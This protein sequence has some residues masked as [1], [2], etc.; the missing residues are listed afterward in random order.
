MSY[1]RIVFAVFSLLFSSLAASAQDRCALS[2]V[3]AIDVSS[4]VN[5]NEYALQ[6][7]GLANALRDDDVREAIRFSGGIQLMAFEWSGRFQQI[8]V[9]P[10]IYLATDTAIFGAA[11]RIASHERSYADL[12]TALGFALG[13]ASVQLQNAPLACSRQAIDVSGDGVSNDGFE[14]SL[15]Y[16]NFVFDGVQVNGL[17]I[18]GATPDPVKY[19]R[20]EVIY[21]PGAFIE[22]AANFDDFERAMKRKLLREINGSSLSMLD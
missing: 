14:P 12:P 16:S 18:A 3:L 1:A 8:E 5:A 17:V 22:V 13:H 7:Q 15:A 20:D 11:D 21:G 4:S 2:L 9:L 19:Y 6:M 10:W